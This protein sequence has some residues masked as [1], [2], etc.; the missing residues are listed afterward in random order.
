M[1]Q[2]IKKERE[3]IKSIEKIEIK[4]SWKIAIVTEIK[5]KELWNFLSLLSK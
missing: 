2:K 3:I 5:E 4:I 1:E